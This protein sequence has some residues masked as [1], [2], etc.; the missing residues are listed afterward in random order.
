MWEDAE[1]MLAFRGASTYRAAMPKLQHWCNEASVAHWEQVSPVLP[2]WDYT[3]C[4]LRTRGHLSKVL[5]PSAAQ[6]IGII[7]T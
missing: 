4:Q 2:S 7:A 5:N 3:A 1:S 6:R